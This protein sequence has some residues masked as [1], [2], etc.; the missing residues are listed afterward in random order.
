MSRLA[1]ARPAVRPQVPPRILVA[2]PPGVGPLMAALD[3]AERFADRVVVVD[4]ADG[5][6]LD[7]ADLHAFDVVR[8]SP[9]FHAPELIEV[10]DDIEEAALVIHPL[11]AWWA[12]V[13]GLKDLGHAGQWPKADGQVANLVRAIHRCRGPVIATSRTGLRTH[14]DVVEGAEQARFI[15]EGPTLDKRLVYCWPLIV[16]VSSGLDFTV[17]ASRVDGIT[18]GPCDLEDLADAYTAWIST[19]APIIDAADHGVLVGAMDLDDDAARQ[20]IKRD[21]HASFGNP[22]HLPAEQLEAAQAFIDRHTKE[23]S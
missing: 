11:S 17:E 7:L 19:A 13:G 3:L 20:R 23:P 1:L 16:R 2:G 21:F 22:S 6:S 18:V 15:A 14:V 10:L 8:W 9:P 5:E 12:G 4:A